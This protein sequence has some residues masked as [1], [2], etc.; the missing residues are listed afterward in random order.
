MSINGDERQEGWSELTISSLA[1]RSVGAMLAHPR[2]MTNSFIPRGQP[3][4]P[5]RDDLFQAHDPLAVAHVCF[6]SQD[7]VDYHAEPSSSTDEWQKRSD[8]FGWSY[9]ERRFLVESEGEIT[10]GMC[11]VDR[12][13]H[14]IS[15]GKRAGKSRAKDTESYNESTVE[16]A[17][18]RGIAHP[19]SSTDPEQQTNG[20]A[21]SNGVEHDEEG[22]PGLISVVT[23]SPGTGSEWF[24]ELFCAS[25]GV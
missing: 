24:A 22:V 19:I 9:Q 20:S 10:R 13:L 2:K 14:G 4:D 5:A 1:L 18:A 15:E 16:G 21:T 7:T 23:D 6:A 11:V 12:R 8:H 17:T 25:L 3:F